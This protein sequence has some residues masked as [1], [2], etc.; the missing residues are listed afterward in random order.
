[1]KKLILL[2]ILIPTLVYSQGWERTFGG[3]KPDGGYSVQQTTDGGYIVAGSS[4]KSGNHAYVY[5]IKT[6][7]NGDTLWT[8]AYWD[9]S[10]GHDRGYSVQQTNDSGY[11]ITG[12]CS[13]FGSGNLYT[14]LIKTDHN[15]DI[16]WTKMFGAVMEDA[17]GN[18]VQK[19]TDGGYVI[20]G[21][22]WT[23]EKGKDVQLI[24]TDSNGDTLWTKKYGGNDNE[25]GNSVQQTNDGGY[26]IIGGINSIISDTT[27][28]HVYLIKTDN[29][30]DT[31]WTKTYGDNDYN[32]GKSIQQT[33][34]GGFIIAGHTYS[35]N[36][37]HDVYLIKTDY[38]GDTL[39]TKTF[40]GEYS[41]EGYSVQQTTDGGYII[42]GSTK[43]IDNG[44]PDVYLIKTDNSGDTLWTKTFGGEYTDFGRSVQQ[45]TDG[46]YIVTGNTFPNENYADVY[47]IKTDENGIITFTT[48]FPAP[49]PNR[50]LVKLV[51]L[52]GRVIINPQKNQPYIEIY[53]DGTT[54]K[55]MQL[56]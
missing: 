18:S 47:L 54:Q 28:T 35:W 38:N 41:D 40:G 23:I 42:T 25:V 12:E 52:S 56:K 5:L 6:D 13:S 32:I 14:F 50:K 55:K 51:D 27:R 1:M 30:G 48:E 36:G 22:I 43:L 26:I 24:K 21:W 8:K 11:I 49:N 46:G 4:Y 7:N 19:T 20:A 15:G 39:W 45:T 44:K 10:T 17:V 31:L 16:L 33:T 37:I 9:W 29:N 2:L 3:E 53:D 34:D